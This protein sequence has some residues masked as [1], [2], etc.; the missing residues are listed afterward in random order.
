VVVAVNTV[1]VCGSMALFDTMSIDERTTLAEAWITAGHEQGLYIIVNVGTTVVSEAQSLA[2]H[3]LA[4]G[5]DAI[6]T[7]PPVSLLLDF[8]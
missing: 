7:V 2:K 8:F 4:H 6:A 1:F 3:A 5:A